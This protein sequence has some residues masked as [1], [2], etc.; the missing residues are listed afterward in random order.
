MEEEETEMVGFNLNTLGLLHE[1]ADNAL[2]MGNMGVLKVPLNVFRQLLGAV[3]QR[4]SEINDPELNIL[5]LRLHL[6]EVPPMEI[7][8]A[9]E[10]QKKLIKKP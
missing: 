6:Y 10:V 3:A 1:I 4:A 8:E 2:P 7:V 5:M 9:I